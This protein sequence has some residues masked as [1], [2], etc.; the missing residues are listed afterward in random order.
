MFR[1]PYLQTLDETSKSVPF[2][3]NPSRKRSEWIT[4]FTFTY[5]N[6][7]CNSLSVNRL[8]K[9]LCNKILTSENCRGVES[10][11]TSCKCCYNI[12]LALM[13]IVLSINGLKKNYAQLCFG[14]AC[15]VIC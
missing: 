4:D 13:V 5:I 10:I 8:M 7:Y 12:I 3:G 14:G 6:I 15:F 11:Q 9:Y 1:K 2:Y